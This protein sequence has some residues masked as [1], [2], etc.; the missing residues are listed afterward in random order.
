[1]RVASVS[2]ESGKI[3][4]T[5]DED[6]TRTLMPATLT[7]AEGRIFFHTLDELV[8][9]DAANGQLLWKAARPIERRRLA[10]SSPTVVAYDGI[11]YAA[12]RA[13]V[14]KEGKLLWLPSGGYHDYIKGK[15]VVGK[16]IAY[17]AKTGKPLWDCEAWE[18]FNSAVD[19]FIAD[20]LLWT[21][22]YAWGNDPGITQGRD[23]KTGE[24]KRKRPSDMTVIGKTGHARCH[25]SKATSKYLIVGRRGIDMVDIKSGKLT[26][27]FWVRGICAYGILPANGLIYA[28]PHS[29]ACSVN[30]ML[31]SGYVALAPARPMVKAD[32]SERLFKGP[33]FGKTTDISA[34]KTSPGDWPT[35]RN[36]PARSGYAKTSVRAELK[37]KWTTKIDGTLTPPV[38]AGD[39]LLVAAKEQHA[40]YALDAKTGEER[41]RFTAGGR[42]DSPPTIVLPKAEAQSPAVCLFGSKDGHVYCVRLADG[43]RVWRYRAAPQDRLIMVDGQIESAWPVSGSVLV[44]GN[45]A[46]FAAGRSSFLDGG[47]Y[48]HSLDVTTG[49][50]IQTKQLVADAKKRDSGG[51]GGF[52]P[53][54]LA[55]NGESIF[56][57][58]ESFNR[59]TLSYKKKAGAA[60]IWSSV[61]FLDHNWWH[62]TY[63]QYG[64][65]MGS[66]W[67]G[68][69]RQ[70]QVAPVG[71]LLVT[72][73]SRIYGYGRTNYDNSGGHV[74]VDGRGSWG[75][76]RNP[77]T[78]HHLFGRD[79]K[80]KQKKPDW[81][82]KPGVL[83]QSMVL[84]D[85]LLF[86]AGPE[87]PLKD[88]PKIPTA[89]DVLD[90]ALRS[91]S[92]GK[93]LAV[94][95]KDGKTL[96]VHELS[97]SPVF[98]GMIAAQGRL[99]LA[100]R[101]GEVICME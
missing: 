62:R 93:L 10:W 63:W 19:I 32:A 30:G 71:R 16:L 7:L 23:P 95:T 87:D 64:T 90:E 31:K 48:L 76:V 26:A 51:A 8:C 65:T 99:F 11:V 14:N 81:S 53:D 78:D 2:P 12:D 47:I 67:G 100:T 55:S 39:L 83:G 9:L 24:V 74:G 17:D 77:F 36:D 79:L 29:C 88:V 42:I 58:G 34:G 75:P 54:V 73:G 21:G 40:V 46:Y 22:R 91:Q 59:K 1:M 80:G 20:G 60:Q 33:A 68:W 43:E 50:V 98:D 18:G 52:L 45:T 6:Y 25:R 94:S 69:H 86:I 49:K 61:G 27:N 92:G 35:Y 13:A 82:H 56:M 44:M 89:V 38:V 85:K 66:G 96:A 28:P 101:S 72:D 5:N 41:W 37:T 3:N 15:N 84:T 4:W 97:S 57:R 70:A